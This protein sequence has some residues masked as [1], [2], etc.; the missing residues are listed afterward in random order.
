MAPGARMTIASSWASPM[1]WHVLWQAAVSWK[2]AFKKAHW[3]SCRCSMWS[4]HPII[5]S[6]FIS[7]LT[8]TCTSRILAMQPQPLSILLIYL[9]GLKVSKTYS[10][11]LNQLGP[12][13]TPFFLILCMRAKFSYYQFFV[14]AFL[15][16]LPSLPQCQKFSS[17]RSC[18]P[19]MLQWWLYAPHPLHSRAATCSEGLTRAGNKRQ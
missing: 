11:P 1:F 8:F 4:D 9:P 5:T 18:M 6:T 10:G 7:F 15:N 17:C 3:P 2:A 14:A 16:W 19:S 13:I 12:S